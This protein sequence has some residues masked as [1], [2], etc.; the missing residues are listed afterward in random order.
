[1]NAVAINNLTKKYRNNAAIADLSIQIGARQIFGFVG[2]DGA[3]KTSLFR[4]LCGVLSADSGTVVALGVD[5]LRRPEKLKQKLGYLSQKFSLYNDL[6][7]IENMDFFADLFKTPR[8]LLHR[9]EEL[10]EFADLIRFKRRL[11]GDLSGGMRQKLALC[12]SL[13]HTPELLV[14]D[15]PTTGVDP[16]SR[17][18]F[19][20]MLKPLPAQGTTVIV[21]TAYMD[22]A[23]QC[24]AIALM[25]SGHIL[26]TGAPAALKKPLM[27]RILE[28]KGE[29]LA[30]IFR[31]LKS[32]DFLE[33]VQEFGDSLHAR[34]R[35]AIDVSEGR[36]RAEAFLR[37]HDFRKAAV[38]RI[39]PSLEDVFI[40]FLREQ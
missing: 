20:E 11:A 32:C 23:D 2:P 29:E 7:V 8:R 13:I 14:L 19:W 12:C 15:E 21:S 35:Q 25:N 27:G 28:I 22:E 1:M 34:L 24:D 6:T 17:Q 39:Q 30:K 5:V 3:G 40:D 4:I 9:K 38:A 16:V 33:E 36:E 37:E 26:Q 18:E 10:L 31:L